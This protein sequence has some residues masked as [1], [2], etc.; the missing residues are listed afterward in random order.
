MQ[1]GPNSETAQICSPA[2]GAAP[3]NP[4]LGAAGGTL[5]Q[6]G[7]WKGLQERIRAEGEKDPP[8]GVTALLG[9]TFPPWGTV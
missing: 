2:S 8:P 6:S 3:Q 1:F 7:V 5:V 4:L 9:D